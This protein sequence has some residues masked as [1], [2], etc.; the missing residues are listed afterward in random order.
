LTA[1][2]ASAIQLKVT[3]I[4]YFYSITDCIFDSNQATQKG[5]VLLSNTD[6]HIQGCQFLHN[7]VGNS[8]ILEGSGAGVYLECP[9][10]TSGCAV[11]IEKCS[12]LSNS[13]KRSGGGIAWADS[14]PEL[15]NLV[16]S[17]NSATYGSDVASFPVTLSHAIDHSSLSKEIQS[18]PSGQPSK[19]TLVVYLLDHYS[20]IVSVDNASY[21]TLQPMSPQ[22]ASVSGV[23]RVLAEMGVFTFDDY[24]ITSQP[25]GTAAIGVYT[26]AVDSSKGDADTNFNENI[27]IQASMRYCEVGET[28][29][30]TYCEVCPYGKYNLEA[31]AP[32]ESCPTGAICYGNYT[33]VP[34][35]GYWRLSATTD[36]IWE[37]YES[38]ACLGSPEPPKPLSLTGECAEGYFGNL[39]HGCSAGFSRTGRYVCAVCPEFVINVIRVIGVGIATVLIVV[40][41]IK[42]SLISA[43]RS[44]SP[45]SIYFKIFINYLQLLSAT[46]V[47]DF[48]W[49]SY[50]LQLLKLQESAGNVSEQV[51]SFDCFLTESSADQGKVTYLRVVVVSTLPVL[52]LLCSF[53]LWSVV[54]W[55]RHSSMYIKNHLINSVVVLFFLVHPSIVKVMFDVFNCK[56]LD[57]G[58]SWLSSNLTIR[59][60]DAQHKRYAMGVALPGILLWGVAVPLLALVRLC[61]KR[62][63]L[64]M[65][66]TRIHFG[67]L[68]NGY[69]PERFYW[70]FIIL[71]R[72]MLIITIAVFI[73][74]ISVSIQ[75]LCAM[76]VLVLAVIFQMREAPYITAILNTLEQRAIVVATITV[77]CGL[78]FMTGDLGESAKVVM[79]VVIVVAN[80]YFL[81]LWSVQ[82]C[83]VCAGFISKL[84][85]ALRLKTGLT[86]VSP[87]SNPSHSQKLSGSLSGSGE[88]SVN[89][90]KV[91]TRQYDDSSEEV[92]AAFHRAPR[93]PRLSVPD[94][95]VVVAEDSSSFS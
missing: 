29:I 76:L 41:I 1:H 46:A 48:K 93:E 45:Y 61:M 70:E 22:Q 28:Q 7:S 39:C 60:W 71:Y 8:S 24:T 54:S 74:N 17:N 56:E 77:Y 35:P 52:I 94:N 64:D 26:N 90:S 83:K 9:D 59:C 92:N 16:F 87:V 69:R 82:V 31:S 11:R 15:R 84:L 50:V 18:V 62:R 68:Y 40:L 6:A 4:W 85:I 19:S 63:T 78:W 57:A 47:F 14:K 89:Q 25:G 79:L 13:A 81:I 42:T 44:R 34:E 80:L 27:T 73:F 51:F 55:A 2:A 33:L 20:Q 5:A 38:A 91:R 3:T 53:L 36:T 88:H 58:L 67:F 32:C 72:K 43:H 75:A 95:S 37:C 86:A 30:N 66:E 49:P 23:T 10:R 12:F 21:A 65:L